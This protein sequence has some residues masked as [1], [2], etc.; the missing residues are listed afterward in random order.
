MRSDDIS[1]AVERALTEYFRLNAPA[2]AETKG[3]WSARAFRV[4]SPEGKFFLKVYDKEEHSTAQ[5]TAN[6]EAY[7][8]FV[9]RLA[10]EG[11]RG[12]VPEAVPAE[13]G[14]LWAEDGRH[15]YLLTGFLPGEMPGSRPLTGQEAGE[16]GEIV[17]RLHRTKAAP[18][19]LISGVRE[20]FSVPFAG[21]LAAMA[22]GETD[23]PPEAEEIIGLHRGAVA[24]LCQ[25]LGR[26]SET[27][28]GK[29]LPFVPCHTD[30]HGWNL[31]SGE[32]LVLLDWEGLRM[33]P[34]EADF[35]ALAGIRAFPALW[36]AYRRVRPGAEI[37]EDALEFYRA[38][39]RCE[40]I[41][42]FAA[43]AVYDRL[44][45]KTRRETLAGLQS[46][47]EALEREGI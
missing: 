36:E 40:D 3:G 13:D 7:L 34:M 46:E 17:G 32:R 30:I 27:M 11:L 4:E 23:L 45:E 43:R 6:M 2:A 47:C 9:N 41:W 25:R 1:A 29:A 14:R 15:L 22:R 19:D 44:D 37:R 10:A 21:K 5:W 31:L 38:R 8:P 28:A 26:L 39:R 35:F 24:E 12:R 42:E 16:L 33:A 20:D 18:D